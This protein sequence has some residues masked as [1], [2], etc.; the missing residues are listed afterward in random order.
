VNGNSIAE[1]RDLLDRYIGWFSEGNASRIA[2][3]AYF[4]P[5]QAFLPT[6]VVAIP[7]PEAI[8][9]ALAV[10]IQALRA[11]GY[12]RSSRPDPVVSILNDT[13]AIASGVVTRFRADGTVMESMGTLY[14]LGKSAAGWRIVSVVA[15]DRSLVVRAS[16]ATS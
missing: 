5:F 6:G 7:T 15:H 3:E 14:L 1:I 10:A 8:E 16:P 2:R 9:G 4:A 13:S 11:A 12:A